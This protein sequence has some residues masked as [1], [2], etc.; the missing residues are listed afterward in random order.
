MCIDLANLEALVLKHLC[1]CFLDLFN[2][3]MKFPI[4][5]LTNRL[6]C[7]YKN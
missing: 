5:M 4:Q 6:L 7:D 1:Y 2:E 3:V